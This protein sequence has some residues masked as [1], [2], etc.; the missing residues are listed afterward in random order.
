VLSF[1]RAYVD[2][3]KKTILQSIFSKLS[4]KVI[5]IYGLVIKPYKV[6]N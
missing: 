3:K 6:E 1:S 2:N 5:L 4:L